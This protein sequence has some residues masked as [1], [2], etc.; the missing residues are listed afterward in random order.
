MLQSIRKIQ[1]ALF[2]NVDEHTTEVI[3]KSA[4]SSVVKA[5]GMLIALLVSIFLGRV[6]GASGLGIINLANRIAAIFIVICLLGMQQVIIKEVAIGY[7]KKNF[8]YIGDV[9]YSSYFINGIISLV[10]SISIILLS[11]WIATSIFKDPRLT[12]PLM[13]VF[14]V[15]PFQVLSRIYSS[16]LV[17]F[18]KIWQSNLVDQTLSIG[19]TGLLLLFFNIIGVE[20]SINL[21]AILYAIG[22]ISVTLTVGIYWKKLYTYKANRHYIGNTLLKTSLP[23]FI[24]TISNILMSNADAIILGGITN[25]QNVGLYTVAAQIALLTTF[26]LQVT[27]SSVSPKIA[28]LYSDNKKDELELMIQ[29]TTAGLFVFGFLILLIFIFAGRYILSM[30][31][32]EFKEGHYILVILGFGQFI[33][34]STGAVGLMLIMT[35]YERI[36]AKISVIFMIINITLSFILIPLL[37]IYGAAISTSFAIGGENITKMILVKKYTN[38]MTFNPKVISNILLRR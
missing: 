13:I 18:R 36:Q 5:V 14:M 21:V 38:I 37:G 32:A 22:R 33:N 7:S 25:S 35:G 27:N 15:L 16:G 11:P 2:S 31:G 26:F 9:I 1:S 12:Y 10:L 24:V 4:A 6:L 29:R 3:R 17:G 30:W 8:R 34:L 28:S 23:V 20:L 19:V